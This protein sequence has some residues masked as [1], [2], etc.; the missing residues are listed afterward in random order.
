MWASCGTDLVCCRELR[1]RLL[2]FTSGN[3]ANQSIALVADQVRRVSAVDGHYAAAT[4]SSKGLVRNDRGE[5]ITA[6]TGSLHGRVQ[7]M[8]GDGKTRCT[9][10]R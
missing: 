7:S 1:K 10:E 6:I 8:G 9:M 4:I 3:S 2:D 5:L